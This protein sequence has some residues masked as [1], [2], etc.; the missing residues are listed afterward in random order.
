MFNKIIQFF[1]NLILKFFGSRFD[2]EKKEYLPIVEEI[3]KIYETLT[4]ISK[5]DLLDRVDNFRKQIKAIINPLEQ[6]YEKLFDE[7]KTE[8][9]SDNRDNIL[10]EMN[11]LEDRIY[12][13]EQDVLDEI[14]PEVFAIVK[15]VCRRNMGKKFTVTDQTYE[16]DMIPYDVQLIGGIVIHK[17]MIAEMATGEG[18]T[19]V[20]IMPA[21]LNA[22]SGKGVHIVTVNDYLAERDHQ[23][24]GLIYKYLGLSV[25][26][27]KNNMDNRL[28]KEEY[29]KDIRN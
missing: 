11:E 26:C 5:E 28:R 6:E 24:M 16:W 25:G 15:E 3:N 7:M 9:D 20:A 1:K 17:G 19:L 10:N 8:N 12:N 14:L 23:W 13:E 4:D 22:L 21:L 27:I 2:R 29:K 18:K